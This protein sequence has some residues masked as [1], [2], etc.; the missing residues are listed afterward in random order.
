MLPKI[1][2][3]DPAV[4]EIGAKPGDIIKIIRESETAG[5]SEFFRLVI[6]G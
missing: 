5:Q 2:M 4:K 6:E 3:S 1:K